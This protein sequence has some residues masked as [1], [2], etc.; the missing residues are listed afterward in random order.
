MLCLVAATLQVVDAGPLRAAIR[1]TV[2][3]PAPAVIDR[4]RV[5]ALA[6]RSRAIEVFP[7]YG[8]VDAQI[9]AGV[10]PASV[11]PRLTQAN[12][13]V[14]LIAARAGLPTNSVYLSHLPT[15]CR[16]EAVQRAAPLHAGTLYLFLDAP[17]PTT[18]QLGGQ[19][20]A[21]VCGVVDW[22]RYCLIP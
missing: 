17:P 14:E 3:G 2:A 22:L 5:T 10:D 7:N 11:W 6:G 18:E 13:E 21:H 4:G 12:V 20:P 8:C 15:D 9:A 19:D 16:A 1:A